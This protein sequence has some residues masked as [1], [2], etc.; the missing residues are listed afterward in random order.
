MADDKSISNIPIP[1][2]ERRKFYD[3]GEVSYV[4]TVTGFNGILDDNNS[5]HDTLLADGI[6]V[7]EPTNILKFS[8]IYV[9]V[10]SDVPSAVDGLLIEQ[11]YKENGIGTI[12]WDTDDKYTIPAM[13][14][15]TFSIQPAMEYMRVTYTNGDALQTEFRLHVV[16]KESMA[17]PSSHRIQDPI[18]GDDDA[19]LVKAVLTGKTPSGAFVNVNTN[20]E[21]ALST[22]DFLFE[23]ARRNITGIKM[24]S[25]P[26]R[27]DSISSI[28]L[29]DLTEVPGTTVIT[30]PANE[31]LELVST[32]INDTDGGT[33]SQSIDI[34]YLDD[35]GEEQGEV[36]TLNGTTPVPTIAANITF[37][38]WI[39]SK[40]VGTNGV[41]EGNIS[42][43]GVGAGPVYE[44]ITSGGNQSLAAKYKVPTGKTGYVVGWQASGITKKIDLRLRATVE[45]FDRT[46]I[47]GI[48]LFQ[49]ILVLDNGTSGYIPF[50]V[51]LEMPAG[52]VVKMSAKSNAAGG[53][54]AGQFDII[55]ID[56]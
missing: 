44:Y 26:G 23:V 18:I 33:G 6:F 47:D 28:V 43:R 14:G 38:Q 29:D 34:Y 27:K 35:N 4:R 12:H 9:T 37:I 56:D 7:G 13:S 48:F 17:L 16:A 55:L 40:T 25:I 21:N 20:R 52:A 19:S 45:R 15:K 39:H 50:Y 24:Y 46:L 5:S 42:I 10:Y 32:S 54:A 2:L 11:G 3:D 1:D 53:D 51:P 41:A 8:I 49:D 36:V 30:Y 31:Q 22:T